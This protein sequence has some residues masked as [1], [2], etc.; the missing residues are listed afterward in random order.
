M[1]GPWVYAQAASTMTG[2]TWGPRPGTRTRRLS[3]LTLCLPP[4]PTSSA[5]T[6]R[7]AACLLHLLAWLWTCLVTTD[8]PA[9]GWTVAGSGYC[10]QT[11]SAGHAQV[12]WDR[13]PCSWALCLCP[14]CR[15]LRLSLQSNLTLAAAW[16]S[17]QGS[18]QVESVFSPRP[19][20]TAPKTCQ[21]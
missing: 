10:P 18:S 3:G 8:V 16:R 1:A 6:P 17:A 2:P 15:H 9:G 20:S 13:T 11:G 4:C 12:L 7:S 14:L 19:L 5:R 21:S